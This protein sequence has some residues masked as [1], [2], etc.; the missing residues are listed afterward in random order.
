[1]ARDL[2]S[3]LAAVERIAQVDNVTLFAL[4]AR[5][6]YELKLSS[7]QLN[8]VKLTHALVFPFALA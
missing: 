6:T 1:M 8:S 4:F 5:S 3:Q 2:E 7:W